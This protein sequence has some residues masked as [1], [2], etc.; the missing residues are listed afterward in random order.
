[1]TKEPREY[2]EDKFDAQLKVFMDDLGE[3]EFK[4]ESM[5][6][7]SEMENKRE[8]IELR[9]KLEALAKEFQGLRTADDLSWRLGKEDMENALDEFG[10]SLKDVVSRWEEVLPE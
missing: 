2:F 10:R 6:W 1:M 5:G 4:V 7:E 9:L 8:I 3:L